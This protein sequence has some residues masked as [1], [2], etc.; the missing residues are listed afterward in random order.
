MY[1]LQLL[2]IIGCL[3]YSWLRF[4]HYLHP[5]FIFSVILFVHYSDFLLRGYND[6]NLEMVPVDSLALYQLLTL[7]SVA[8]TILVAGALFGRLPTVFQANTA[9]RL[10]DAL[11]TLRMVFIAGAI[12]LGLEVIKR[13]AASDWSPV[14]VIDQMLGPRN[15]RT[16][17][18]AGLA[19]D[20]EAGNVV[21]NPIFQLIG[22]LVPL[23]PL[24]FA[25]VSA[26]GR[27]ALR[28]ISA[29]FYVITIFILVTDG[30]RAP[31]LLAIAAG[32]IVAIVQ[33][34]SLVAR[35]A[36]VA[37]GIVAIVATSSLMI[38][39]R[40]EGFGDAL[41]R[42]ARIE[43]V[44]HQDD[45]IYRAW[46]AYDIAQTS[47]YR[48]DPLYFAYTVV[49][50]P[51]PRTIWTSKP[52]ASQHFYGDYKIDYVTILH[53][54]EFAAM[55]GIYLGTIISTIY[56]LIICRLLFA[57]QILLR[58]PLGI[59]AYII[60]ALWAY[61]V[62]RSIANITLLMYAPLAAI[63]IAATLDRTAK[64]ALQKRRSAGFRI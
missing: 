18:A 44:Y 48:W 25:Y 58:K 11:R 60:C 55:F 12:I 22:T 16:W 6:A 27:G 35:I 56:G 63:A 38:A 32:V 59:G 40:A 49:A 1:I 43:A 19:R 3:T 28:G 2:V 61:S 24:M 14:W 64:G 10:S 41:S 39:F 54:G 20:I 9:L 62:F 21:N 29:L 13:L 15:Q 7:I 46:R 33:M 23:A 52:F 26:V 47:G 57:S 31:V 42:D 34:R 50:N 8:A 45:S 53:F 37:V 51:V 5:H 17:L 36:V 4:K 30:T